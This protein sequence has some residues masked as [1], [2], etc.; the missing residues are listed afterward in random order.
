MEKPVVFSFI[1]IVISFILA[2]ALYNYMPA[3][4]VSHWDINGTA[5]STMPKLGALFIIPLLSLL[6]ILIFYYLPRVDPFKE[7][8]KLFSKYYS[9][10]IFV[11]TA[12]LFYT[13]LQNYAR[14][15]KSKTSL[16]KSCQFW[17]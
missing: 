8:Y 15:P 11:L 6:L 9:G 1:L 17:L 12:F 14:G 7:N 2:L 3:N 4:M 13:Y 10:F 16:K 5:N